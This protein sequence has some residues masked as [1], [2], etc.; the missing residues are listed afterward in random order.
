MGIARYIV[1]GM[2]TSGITLVD[3]R[4][5]INPDNQ[6]RRANKQ[7][8]KQTKLMEEMARAQNRPDPNANR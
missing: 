8:K 6:R 5:G 2:L 4:S 3:P 1:K 7:L